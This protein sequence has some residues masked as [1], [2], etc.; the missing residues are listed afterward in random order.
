MTNEAPMSNDERRLAAEFTSEITEDILD[1]SPEE[2]ADGCL[3][4]APEVFPDESWD[5]EDPG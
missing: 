5:D 3:V 4:L 2:W 1:L